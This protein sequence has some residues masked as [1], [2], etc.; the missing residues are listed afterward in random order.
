[1]MKVERFLQHS[2]FHLDSKRGKTVAKKSMVVKNNKKFEKSEKF[3]KVRKEL[4]KL[5]KNPNTA[6]E[7]RYEAQVKLGSLP[8]MSLEIRV[9]NRCKI[10]GRPRGYLR[11]F[12]MS[13]IA[14]RE[15]ASRGLLPGVIK[16][17][18]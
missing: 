18:W 9:K 12:Q 17:S 4:R 1:M 6:P 11:K 15:N 16:A 3:R 10:T 2:A 5:I 13:R 8:K 14:F 7:A